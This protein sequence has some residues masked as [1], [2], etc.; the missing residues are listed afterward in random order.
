MPTAPAGHVGPCS[1]RDQCHK[2][3]DNC[4]TFLRSCFR[5]LP[6]RMNLPDIYIIWINF[7]DTRSLPA[8]CR[9]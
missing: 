3:L 9:C 8:S 1:P 6:V 5:Q 4:E 7:I 2:N